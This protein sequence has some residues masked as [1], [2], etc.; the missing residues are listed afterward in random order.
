MKR[1]WKQNN[2]LDLTKAN[3][4][5]KRTSQDLLLKAEVRVGRSME[6]KAKG[7]AETEGTLR[8][9]RV[10]FQKWETQ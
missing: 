9:R 7:N 4:E 6:D 1:I 5:N 3:T 2:L 8:L 10:N